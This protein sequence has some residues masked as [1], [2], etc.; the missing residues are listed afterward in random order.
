MFLIVYYV[1]INNLLN[2]KNID[3]LIDNYV[4]INNLLNNKNIDILVCIYICMLEINNVFYRVYKT[5]FK[6][7]LTTRDDGLTLYVHIYNLYMG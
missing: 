5:T 3:I 4:I 2:N 7:V 6:I 1:I